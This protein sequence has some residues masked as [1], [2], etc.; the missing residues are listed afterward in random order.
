ML[1]VR[2]VTYAYASR[3]SAPEVALKNIS[4]QVAKGSLVLITGK[5]GSGKTTLL[6]I[7]CG[8]L[9]PKTGEVTLNCGE[10][11]GRSTMVFQ[12]PEDSFFKATVKEEVTFGLEE[13]GKGSIDDH[14]VKAMIQCGLRAELYSQRSPLA[15]SGGEQRLVAIAAA[16]ALSR[17]LLLFDE[18][19][20]GL[21][22][23]G[24]DCVRGIL[25]REAVTGKIIL[26]ATHWP[27]SFID[28]ATHV[29]ALSEGKLL[30]FV[31]VEEY[32]K[33]RLYPD[34]LNLRE[35]FLLSYYESKARFPVESSQLLSFARGERNC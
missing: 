29:I 19:T 28:L 33:K 25:S 2:D 18:P 22:E 12:Y 6:E 4:F 5:T 3:N 20:C 7:L 23:E 11:G 16:L 13:T 34:E 1:K 10:I 31:T 26:V 9:K 15:L 17:E 21:D 35:R 8:L 30:F 14:Y 32:I 27:L 24:T